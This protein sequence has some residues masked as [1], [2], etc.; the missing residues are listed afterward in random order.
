VTVR[1]DNR[2]PFPLEVTVENEWEVFKH[3]MN[4]VMK[5]WVWTAFLRGKPWS[6]DERKPANGEEIQV[7]LWR[8][9]VPV[10]KAVQ[11]FVQ[12][13]SGKTQ[14]THLAEGNELAH[15]NEW[16]HGRYPIDRWSASICGKRWE[17]QS[18]APTRDQI[19]RVNVT[20]EGG[21][22]KTGKFRVWI[23]LGNLPKKSVELLHNPKDCWRDFCG[24]VSGELEH[25]AWTAWIQTPEGDE[26]EIQWLD[27]SIRPEKQALIIVKI[28]NE[29]VSRIDLDEPPPVPPRSIK[30]PKGKKD[31][32]PAELKSWEEIVPELDHP[33]GWVLTEAEKAINRE[34][35]CTL[36][37]IKAWANVKFAGQFLRQAIV[38]SRFDYDRAI[39]NGVAW[40]P[41]G[42]DSTVFDLLVQIPLYKWPIPRDHGCFHPFCDHAVTDLQSCHLQR[43][44]DRKRILQSESA[45]K[46]QRVW[47]GESALQ[48]TMADL[49]DIWS[50]AQVGAKYAN[51]YAN[52]EE[53]KVGS[54]RA[55]A[56]TWKQ[57][58]VREWHKHLRDFWGPILI[59]ARR[60]NN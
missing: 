41:L 17:D 2:E 54:F 25:D 23:K 57:S 43:A 58:P 31:P 32:R 46:T 55:L 3:C 56:E 6:N 40:E 21:G 20:G 7:Q 16:M 44:H 28:M 51:P 27:D 53:R 19:I 52:A 60:R 33:Q 35:L 22:K 12:V 8:V 48:P 5:N 4:S 13:G 10:Q 49:L 26:P 9:R 36:F 38:A 14:I 11:V 39:P 47:N 15:F 42:T 37:G 24:K 34:V 18:F 30:Y 45:D 59:Y 29:E 50:V 1:I